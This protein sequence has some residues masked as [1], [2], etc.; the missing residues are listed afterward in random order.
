M[1]LLMVR[2]RSG[3]RGG[4]VGV[5]VAAAAAG[6]H[7]SAQA[8]GVGCC[9]CESLVRV[10]SRC[11]QPGR[12]YWVCFYSRSFQFLCESSQC[13][14]R[15]A[16]GVQLHCT[17]PPGSSAGARSRHTPPCL[18]G[19]VNSKLI[20]CPHTPT[21]RP[22]CLQACRQPG[23]RCTQPGRQQTKSHGTPPLCAKARQLGRRLCFVLGSK[24]AVWNA[25]AATKP[26]CGKNTTLLKSCEEGFS[27][28]SGLE[29]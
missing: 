26:V 10:K 16:G 8:A 20:P 6:V 9:W 18:W 27:C 22:H 11:Q 1:L 17:F 19:M 29:G 12:V 2:S 13:M 28:K 14:H 3:G 7:Q 4:T 23:G 25:H 24:S 5:Q 15:G 21:Q